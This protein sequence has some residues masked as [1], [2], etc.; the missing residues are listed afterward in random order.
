MTLD[1][2]EVQVW[3]T[4]SDEGNKGKN[5][6]KNKTKMRA[7][8][9][10]SEEEYCMTSED[11]DFSDFM[12]RAEVIVSAVAVGV[13]PP[14]D[15]SSDWSSSESTGGRT[16]RSP[17]RRLQSHSDKSD[18]SVRIRVHFGHPGAAQLDRDQIHGQK[19]Q[20]FIDR[21]SAINWLQG[22]VEEL[23]NTLKDSNGKIKELT[24]V[25]KK[26]GRETAIAKEEVVQL[27]GVVSEAQQKAT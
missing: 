16:G 10:Q 9:Q 2:I 1:E 20:D 3:S 15:L 13:Q 14:N 6:G 22:R 4:V 18:D 24:K 17:P 27:T 12:A 11:R 8:P 7:K 19:S 26:L 21:W 23:E 25:T 5:K